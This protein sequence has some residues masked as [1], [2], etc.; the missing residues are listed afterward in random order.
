MCH[1]WAEE[2]PVTHGA[3][4]KETGQVGRCALGISSPC[5]FQEKLIQNCFLAA[6]L[7]TVLILRT[8]FCSEGN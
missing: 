1:S 5:S 2:A 6:D 3:T 4:T 7:Y 8:P